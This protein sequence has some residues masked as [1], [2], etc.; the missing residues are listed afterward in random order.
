MSQF[1][2]SGNGVLSSVAHDNDV[3]GAVIFLYDPA[4]TGYV[5]GKKSDFAG[6]SISNVAV[7]GYYGSTSSNSTPT[8]GNGTILNAGNRGYF[9]IQ[10]LNTG[11]LYV[12][13][14]AGISPTSFNVILKGGVSVDDGLGAY[15]ENDRWKGS[16]SVSGFELTSGRYIFSEIY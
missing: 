4:V 7:S 9:Y 8:S 3:R 2:I 11:A 14:G 12:K 15:L 16:V 10:N 6:G 5:P 13:Y 1:T